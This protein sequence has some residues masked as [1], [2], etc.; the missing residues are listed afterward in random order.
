MKGTREE[1][2]I[3]TGS[4]PS[5]PEVHHGSPAARAP[6]NGRPHTF[7]S[8]KEK[9]SPRTPGSSRRS[10]RLLEAAEDTLFVLHPV[11]HSPSIRVDR[12]IVSRHTFFEAC[13]PSVRRRL[14]Q[15]PVR[16]TGQPPGTWTVCRNL[17]QR[18]LPQW[19]FHMT[20]KWRLACSCVREPICS[21]AM[22][23]R[24]QIQPK[25]IR[26]EWPARR[27]HE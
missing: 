19:A 21:C 8:G 14:P 11:C 10:V 24:S 17:R 13:P 22:V 4:H 12:G 20:G 27:K 2:T 26:R 7:A 18:P 6:R 15:P 3:V 23:R 9:E 5:R 25:S 1:C 16:D